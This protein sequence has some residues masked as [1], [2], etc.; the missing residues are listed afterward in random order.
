LC[1]Y[2]GVVF[3]LCCCVQTVL[4]C[5]DC[6]VVFR[7]WCCVQLQEL[8]S[9]LLRCCQ[10]DVDGFLRSI[11]LSLTSSRRVFQLLEAGPRGQDWA[12]VLEQVGTPN[13]ARFPF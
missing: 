10:I 11:D 13:P 4:L 8:T 3:R 6:V 9:R 2:C 5:S 1:S 7:L 12:S